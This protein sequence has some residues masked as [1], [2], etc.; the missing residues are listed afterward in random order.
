MN[1]RLAFAAALLAFGPIGCRGDK[2][3]LSRSHDVVARTVGQD[4]GVAQLSRLLAE[5]VPRVELTPEN[6]VIFA[7]LWSSYHRLAFAAAHDDSLAS[8]VEAGIRPILDNARV[9][10]LLD[11]LRRSMPADTATQAA[12]DSGS[13]GLYALRHLLVPLPL[14]ATPK[15][16]DS[17]HA[18]AASLRRTITPANFGQAASAES[19]AAHTAAK[20]GYLG[21]LSLRTLNPAVGAA[22][23]ALGPDSVSGLIQT[24]LGFEIIQRLSWA[25]AKAGYVRA[26]AQ[27]VRQQQDSLL[28]VGAERAAGVSVTA[29]GPE[30]ARK[31]A[32]NPVAGSRDTTTLATFDRHGVLSAANLLAWVDVMP[33][34]QRAQVLKSLP[35]QSDAQANA[36]IG[37][38]AA[39]AVLLRSADS[40]GI[41]TPDS[42]TASFTRLF[43]LEV[44]AAW[45]AWGIAPAQRADNATTVAARE[46]AAA[47]RVDSLLDD[48][49]TG[50][51]RLTPIAIPVEAALNAQY[52]TVISP[53]A[54]ARAVDAARTL[55]AAS[56]SARGVG[57]RGN[58]P[59]PTPPPGR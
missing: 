16:R 44:V 12:I 8:H 5:A 23:K 37:L 1:S 51:V 21:V 25:N 49:L 11:G 31:A 4:L 42:V 48:G 59:A 17:V 32:A 36:F 24:P 40:A 10:A 54:L 43:F 15:Q 39:R 38:L 33:P 53:A 56:D 20:A 3:P 7:N 58:P 26:Y 57:S 22:A 29:A 34:A 2:D 28:T 13:R 18:L 35:Q 41:S 19:A 52:E 55:R 46:Q 50:R 27:L 9:N 30:A 45:N 6:A 14:N 47:R